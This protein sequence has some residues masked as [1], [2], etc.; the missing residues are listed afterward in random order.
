MKAFAM[1]QLIALHL[2]FLF[3][4]ISDSVGDLSEFIVGVADALISLSSTTTN[5]SADTLDSDSSDGSLE[6]KVEELA[7]LALPSSAILEIG[8]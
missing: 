3:L 2:A 6:L 1:I 7:S 5:S 4:A 8:I